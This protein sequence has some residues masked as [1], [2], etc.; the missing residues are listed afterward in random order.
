MFGFSGE[1]P[2]QSSNRINRVGSYGRRG[3]HGESVSGIHKL[4]VRPSTRPEGMDRERITA[5][6][7]LAQRM[8]VATT[9]KEST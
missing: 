6:L 5:L 8:K 1:P 7:D 9:P 3:S 4:V 2:E